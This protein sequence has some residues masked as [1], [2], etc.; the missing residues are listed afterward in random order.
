V[1]GLEGV[2]MNRIP[3]LRNSYLILNSAGLNTIGRLAYTIWQDQTLSSK[4]DMYIDKLANINWRK[5]A[6]IWAGNIIQEGAKGLKIST[7][8][9]TLKAAV[10]KVKE[11]I[12]LE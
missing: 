2:D 9:S 1:S 4:L 6:D 8:N 5:D 12:G 3:N 10:K 11:G 7:A